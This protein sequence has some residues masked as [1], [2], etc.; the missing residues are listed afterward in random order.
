MTSL[1]SLDLDDYQDLSENDQQLITIIK[2]NGLLSSNNSFSPLIVTLLI[3]LTA[4]FLN[5]DW[6]AK[7]LENIP[8]YKFSLL[9]ILFSMTLVYILFL[10]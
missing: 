5:S 6:V 1:D 3:T 7:K 10:T 9:G 2:P 8:Y 4:V